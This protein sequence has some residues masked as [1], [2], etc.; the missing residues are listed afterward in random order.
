VWRKS[1][2]WG[3]FAA[4]YKTC[5]CYIIGIGSTL[6]VLLQLI[7]KPSARR[8]RLVL[9]FSKGGHG[10]F[11]SIVELIIWM[12]PVSMSEQSGLLLSVFYARGGLLG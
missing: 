12:R 10:N 8:L 11:S 1:Q 3:K 9:G 4:Y 2:A 6:K 5:S 7:G